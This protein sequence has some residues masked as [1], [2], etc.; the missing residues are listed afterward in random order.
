MPI[1]ELR[2]HRGAS[3]GSPGLQGR[4]RDQGGELSKKHGNTLVRTLR[5]VY[6][7]H[8]A[9]GWGA[10]E[11]LADILHELDEP[12]LSKLV[13][14]YEHGN[15][16]EK[17]GGADYLS[18]AA[19]LLGIT[20]PY[21]PLSQVGVIQRVQVGL[22]LTAV[23]R[24]EKFVAPED[25]TFKYRIIPR[26]TWARRR[27]SR[28]LSAKEGAVVARLAEV[29]AMAKTVWGSEEAA[30]DFLWRP[31]PLLEGRKPIDVILESELGRPLVES[32]LGRLQYGSAA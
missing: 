31:H 25:A 5:K 30:R 13:H 15:L 1:S 6:G 4:H 23:T 2:R 11:K 26:A 27:K 16:H 24:L 18:T 3:G 19:G 17:I 8:F 7:D 20:N 9:E 22:P 21:K 28:R 10:K 12:S 29:S 32:I 14:D